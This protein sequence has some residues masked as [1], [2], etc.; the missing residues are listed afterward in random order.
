MNYIGIITAAIVLVA[1][2][3]AVVVLLLR[4][5]QIRYPGM[6]GMLSGLLIITVAYALFTYNAIVGQSN[7]PLRYFLRLGN[8]VEAFTIGMFLLANYRATR[9]IQS[10]AK[11]GE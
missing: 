7:A 11:G 8:G 3:F 5:R 10:K 4:Y 6:L 2:I 1:H 9:H